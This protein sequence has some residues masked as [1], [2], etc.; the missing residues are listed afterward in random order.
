MRSHAPWHGIE[1]MAISLHELTVVTATALETRAVVRALPSVRCIEAGI[2]LRKLDH[3]Q[4]SGLVVSCGLAGGLRDGAGTGTVVVPKS[5][6]TLDGQ[7]IACDDEL[8]SALLDVARG[9]GLVVDEAPLVTSAALITGRERAEWARRGFVAADMETGFLRVPRLAAVRVI[10]DTPQ[11]ELS[12]L[13]LQP[14]RALAHPSIWPQ[15][16][17]LGRNAPRCARLAATV[18]AG[19]VAPA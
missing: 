16:L 17:W 2:A 19:A 10:L 3:R 4:L 14:A 12:P 1:R 6:S 8:R 5:V 15:A 11:R 9:L 13:W 7:S 18:L